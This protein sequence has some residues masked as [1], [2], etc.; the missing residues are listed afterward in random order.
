MIEVLQMYIIGITGGIAC[1]KSTVS[2][3]LSKYGVKIINVDS[4]AHWQMKPGGKIFNAYIN[5][6]GKD[7]LDSAGLIDRRK[8]AAIVFNDSDQLSWINNA[9]HPILLNLVRDRLVKYQRK[10]ITLVAL[11][12]PLLFEAGW[13]NECDQIW[14]VSLDRDK[15]IQRLMQRNHLSKEEAETRINAQMDNDEKIR[16]ADLVIDNNLQKSFVR[17]QINDFIKKR[18]PHLLDVYNNN[19]QN[20]FYSK[21]ERYMGIE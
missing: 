20:I 12:V 8:V 7:I 5:H 14:V 4:I 17:Q 18:F 1:G 21:L 3:E 13:E 16:R 15:Q 2:N 19:I 11:D 6:F 9:A 10:S